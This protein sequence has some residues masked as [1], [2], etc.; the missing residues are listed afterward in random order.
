MEQRLH[1]IETTMVTKDYL[2]QRLL[3]LKTDNRTVVR[4]EDQKF[5]TLVDVLYQRKVL[6]SQDV[7][8]V[9]T[10]QPFATLP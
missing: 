8:L 1:A 6:T 4:R 5:N 10:I 9:M 2:D 7:E 3:D